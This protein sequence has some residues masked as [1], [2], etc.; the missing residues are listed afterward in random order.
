MIHLLPSFY[1]LSSNHQ[2]AFAFCLLKIINLI[3]VVFNLRE[4]FTGLHHSIEDSPKIFHIIYQSCHLTLFIV[5]PF[6]LI[7]PGSLKQSL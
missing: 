3:L 5:I 1:L 4:M 7:P 6:I 2:L